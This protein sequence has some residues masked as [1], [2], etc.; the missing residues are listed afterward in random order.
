MARIDAFLKLAKEQRASDLHFIA[1][2]PPLIRFNGDLFP[3]NFRT[4]TAYDGE[5]FITEILTE[6]QIETFTEKLELDFSYHLDEVAHFRVNVFRQ[7]EGISAVFRIIPDKVQTVAE[8]GLPESL[9]KFTKISKGM[10]LV[11][12]PTGSGKSTTLA[13]IINEIN[14]NQNRHILTLE[15]PIEFVHT[16]K[17]CIIT[18]REIHTHSHSFANALRSA[19][20]E[21]PDVILVGEMRDL[22]TIEQALTCA[23][24]G[25][26][27]FATLH[28]NS[29]GST[30]DRIIDVFPSF[31]QD[32]VRT[33]LS[34]TLQGV[35][36]QQL[37]PTADGLS[38]VA[39]LEILGGSYALSNLIREGKTHQIPTLIQSADESTGM[40]TLDQHLMN[41]V[42]VGRISAHTAYVHAQN[43]ESFEDLINREREK[44]SIFVEEH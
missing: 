25:I 17:K 5:S 32:Q 1:G 40:Q 34:V 21:A 3:I 9:K 10:V 35:I 42:R 22:E 2:S 30:I 18:Q 29:A 33:M 4:L 6:E 27:V 14:E 12:G 13:A 44:V 39:A 37:V 36:S 31:Q 23:E 28:T 43:K 24:T 8:L 26:L 19:L 16:P 20:R 38:R 7:R 15:D 41:L 11:T